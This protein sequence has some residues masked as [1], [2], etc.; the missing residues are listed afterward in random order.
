MN[1]VPSNYL[2]LFILMLLEGMSLPIPSEVVM[3]LAG[4]LSSLGA[5]NLYL[6]ILIGSLGSLVG[7]LIDYF[8]ALK[9]G[10]PFLLRYGKYIK[11][12]KN[13]LDY[14]NT[15]FAKHGNTSVF[16]ARFLPAIRALISFPAGIARM[17][18]T[19]FILFTFSG[20]LVWDTILSFIGYYFGSSWQ[21]IISELTKFD[22]IILSIV[23]IALVIYILIKYNFLKFK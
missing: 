2:I 4:Y 23:L 1:Y 11:L 19:Y 12:N 16:F 14:L 6:S 8:I 22:Y 5:L 9:L 13:R 15:F 20:H 21:P 10:L 18:L 3:P 17:R 7:S